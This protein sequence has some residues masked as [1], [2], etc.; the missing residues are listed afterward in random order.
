MNPDRQSVES[1]EQQED[2]E[3]AF[4]CLQAQ[5]K[6]WP[7]KVHAFIAERL[8]TL[9]SKEIPAWARAA[10]VLSTLDGLQTAEAKDRAQLE[11]SPVEVD[12]LLLNVD[13][14][15]SIDVD[16][17]HNSFARSPEALERYLD[18]GKTVWNSL[19]IRSFDRK[20]ESTELSQVSL[21]EL[22]AALPEGEPVVLDGFVTELKLQQDIDEADIPNINDGTWVVSRSNNGDFFA[23]KSYHD[24]YGNKIT[25]DVYKMTVTTITGDGEK[26]TVFV[27]RGDYIDPPVRLEREQSDIRALSFDLSQSGGSESFNYQVFHS[28]LPV[29]KRLVGGVAFSSFDAHPHS[30]SQ[31]TEEQSRSIEKGVKSVKRLFGEVDSVLGVY[32]REDV[33]ANASASREGLVEMK[34]GLLSALRADPEALEEVVEH[35][36]FHEKDFELGISADSGLIEVWCLSS[37]TILSEFDEKHFSSNFGG[38]S[39]DNVLEFTASLLNSLDDPNWGENFGELSPDAQTLYRTSLKLLDNFMHTNPRIKAHTPIRKLVESR[40]RD[41]GSD[42]SESD[43]VGETPETATLK[44][45]E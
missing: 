2:F 5:E 12:S 23:N 36:L 28:S 25:T 34:T 33:E 7:L 45:I 43:Q 38:H 42:A 41:M 10:M 40:L 21:S 1:H 17:A 16:I 8:R 44:A 22:N 39:A 3:T 26:T 15:P 18:D 31:I 30:L 24:A 29:E 37:P 4:E 32:L 14:L 27:K 9:P 19:T 6:S 20:S 13:A 35:E 11:D